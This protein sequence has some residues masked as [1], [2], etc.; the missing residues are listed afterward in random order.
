MGVSLERRNGHVASIALTMCVALVLHHLY[1]PCQWG[2]KAFPDGKE[3]KGDR[4]EK[5]S[6]AEGHMEGSAHTISEMI[7]R[8]HNAEHNDAFV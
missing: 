2:N 1:L 3:K 5:P 8:Q 7:S 4:I 6:H